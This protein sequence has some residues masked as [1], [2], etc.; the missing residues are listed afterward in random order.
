MNQNVLVALGLGA[1]ILGLGLTLVNWLW[2]APVARGRGGGVGP[3]GRLVGGLS[4]RALLECAA[5]LLV[6]AGLAALTGWVPFVVLLPVI[7]VAL[8]RLF[9]DKAEKATIALLTD[10]EGWTRSLSGLIRTGRNLSA[11]LAASLPNANGAMRAPVHRMVARISSGWSPERA[12]RAFAEDLDDPTGDLVVMNL[13]SAVRNPGDGLKEALDGL[14]LLVA[15]DVQIR[16]SVSAERSKPRLNA[17]IVLYV[18]VAMVLCVPFIP[19]LSKGYSSPVGQVIF[20][21][22]VAAI[23][24]V[25]ARMQWV[26]RPVHP[27]RLLEEVTP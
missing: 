17:K 5:G 21:V 12:L 4:K 16:R 20:L 27:P 22:I 2:P 19:M 26:V 3:L 10:L 18:T 6:G 9:S 11:A 14:A 24:L 15:E 8:P 25:L 23:A 7:A 13:I 1:V